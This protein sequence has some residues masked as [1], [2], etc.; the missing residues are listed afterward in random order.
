ML[1]LPGAG[2]GRKQVFVGCGNPTCHIGSKPD[3]QGT[4]LVRLQLRDGVRSFVV[5][6]ISFLSKGV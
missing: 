5:A 6:D 2:V 4:H 1:G 3:R